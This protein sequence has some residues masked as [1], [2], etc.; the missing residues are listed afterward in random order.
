VNLNKSTGGPV[1][2]N[3]SVLEELPPLSDFQVAKFEQ[4]YKN[5]ISLAKA[6]NQIPVLMTQ[7]L[8]KSSKNQEQFNDAIRRVGRNENVEVI[9]LAKYVIEIEKFNLLFYDDGIHFNNDG[10]RWA[11]DVIADKL[12]KILKLKHSSTALRSSCSDLKFKGSSFLNKTP[13]AN[14]F[15]GRYPS[16]NHNE[17]KLL[18]QV[19]NDSGSLLAYLDIKTDSIVKLLENDDPNALEHP[20]WLNDESILYTK[21]S[22]EFRERDVFIL[23]RKTGVNKKLTSEIGFFTAIPF[24]NMDGRI[25]FAGYKKTKYGITPSSIYFMKDLDSSPEL[26]YSN[27]FESWRPI[28]SNNKI[29]FINNKSGKYQIYE[30]E[31][32][33]GQRSAGI[34]TGSDAVQWDPIASSDGMNIAYSEKKLSNFDIYMFDRKSSLNKISKIVGSSSDEWDPRI[35]PKGKY[36]L[37][38]VSTHFGDQIRATCLN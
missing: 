8:G 14:I 18:F 35:S 19:N 27:E 5:F 33:G 30:A 16:F 38:S 24:A 25:V 37:Y 28:I 36:L 13:Y 12:T 22:G 29:L 7:P 31:L 4:N 21:N 34:L 23:N 17:D 20:T 6:N 10:S 1:Y 15:P 3:E 11:A 32:K 2:I 9:D 26:I